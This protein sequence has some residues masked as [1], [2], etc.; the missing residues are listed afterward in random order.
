MI[1][2]STKSKLDC[3]SQ[4]MSISLRNLKFWAQCSF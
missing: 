2:Y 4:V 1:Y 3:R